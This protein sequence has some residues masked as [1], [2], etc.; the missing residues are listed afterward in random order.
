MIGIIDGYDA[1]TADRCYKKGVAPNQ[2]LKILLKMANSELD[3]ELVAKFIKHIGIHPVGSLVKLDSEK[4]SVV[5]E[6]NDAA[7]LSSKVKSF[8]S[9]RSKHY[10]E[11]KDVDLS[12]KQCREKIAYLLR[13]QDLNINYKKFLHERVKGN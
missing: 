10:L 7:P 9:L 3:K 6:L 8:C 13:E 1:M 2:A 11:P 12:Q 4:I 5:T